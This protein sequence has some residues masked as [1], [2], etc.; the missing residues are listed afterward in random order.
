M[1][2]KGFIIGLINSVKVIV[3]VKEAQAF[4]TQP[5][6]RDWTLVIECISANGYSLPTFV[7]FE[8]QRIS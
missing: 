2:E 8:G 6:N 1:D 4:V 3:P 5:N 7:I